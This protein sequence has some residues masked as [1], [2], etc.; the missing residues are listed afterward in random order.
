MLGEAAGRGP[1]GARGRGRTAACSA[2]GSTKRCRPEPP[3]TMEEVGLAGPVGSDCGGVVQR[4]GG[5]SG[6]LAAAGRVAAGAAALGELGRRCSPTT[7]T[8]GLKSS[9]IVCSL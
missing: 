5:V 1:G 6:A 7:L 4:E 9:E 2:R 8:L 3:R